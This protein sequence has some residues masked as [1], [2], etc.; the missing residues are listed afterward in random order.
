MAGNTGRNRFLRNKRLPRSCEFTVTRMHIYEADCAAFYSRSHRA[1]IR[2]Y[3]KAGNMI[4]TDEH[5][6]DFKEP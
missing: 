3:D 2:V 1:V 6:G 5:A 4:E